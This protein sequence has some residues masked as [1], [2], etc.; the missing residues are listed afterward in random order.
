MITNTDKPVKT[1]AEEGIKKARHPFDI[2]DEIARLIREGTQNLP[3]EWAFRLRW[4][5]LFW[6]GPRSDTFMVRIKVP[7]GQVSAR[8]LRAVADLAERYGLQYLDATTRQGLQIRGIAMADIPRVMEGLSVVGLSPM[9]SGADNIRNLTACP[10]AGLNP[11]ELSDVTP[12][13]RELGKRFTGNREFA[14]LPRKFNITLSGCGTGCTHPELADIAVLAV[15]HPH[16]GTVGYTLYVGGQPS[17]S[18]YLSR[19][20]E[21]FLTEDEVPDVCEAIVA[22]FRDHG[23]RTSRKQ[24]RMAHLIDRWG[25][26][27]FRSEVEKMLGRT[28]PW[29]PNGSHPKESAHDPLG[30][31]PQKQE[32]LSFVGVSFPVGRITCTEARVLATLAERYGST[33]LRLTTRQNVLLTDVPEANIPAVCA[34]LTGAG[35][36]PGGNPVRAGVT[37]CSGNTYCKLASVET[38]DRAKDIVDHLEGEGLAH[39]PLTVALSACPNTCALHSVADIG[40]MG[41]KARINGLTQEVFHIFFGGGTGPTARFGE[42]IFTKIPAGRLNEYLSHAARVYQEAR[43]EGE[44]FSDFCRRHTREEL[45]TR[46]TPPK[47][48]PLAVFTWPPAPTGRPTASKT[49]MDSG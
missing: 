13:V 4:H 46:F 26:A 30:T 29:V 20:L 24:A 9:Q 43:R 2:Q 18:H 45:T 14:D 16:Y 1:T 22:V 23:D 15:L 3:K 11:D 40:L 7:G 35:M 38:K 47:T 37:A 41:A 34:G 21:V 5:G 42:R 28:L 31:H 33:A 48:S 19:D 36:N 39:L 25:L 27:V 44:S 8:Q 12:L 49:L 32:G 10:V 6:E 17:T